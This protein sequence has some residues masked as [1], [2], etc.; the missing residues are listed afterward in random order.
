MTNY[1]P[2]PAFTQNPSFTGFPWNFNLS[3]GSQMTWPAGSALSPD[4]RFLYVACNSDNSVAVIDTTQKKL[5]QQVAVGYF[6]YGVS[7]SNDGQTVTVSNW[8]IT[9]YKFTNPTY[10]SGILT[11]LAPTAGNQPDGFYVPVTST[12]GAFPQTS[13]ISILTAP[14]GDG[15]QL[16]PVSSV[17]QGHTLD[18]LNTIGDTHPS[19]T[20]I[21]DN[22]SVQVLYVTKS[23][24]DR[25]GVIT[26]AN[27]ESIADIDLSPLK[28]GGV[29]GN[30]LV[31]AYPNAIVISPDKTR[32]YVAEAGINSVAVL[33]TTNPLQPALLGRIPTGW[34][35][36]ALAI[37]GDGRYLYVANAKGVGEDINPKINTK[38]RSSAPPSGLASDP[39]TDSHCIFGTVQKIDLNSTQLR[40]FNVLANNFS[41]RKQADASVVPIGGGP[42]GKIK[43]VFLFSRRI[44]VRY[45]A[46]QR[47]SFR[48]VRQREFQ[49]PGRLGVYKPAVYGCYRESADSGTAPSPPRSTTIPIRKKAMPAIISAHRELRPTIPRRPC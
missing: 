37:S 1:T 8:G 10:D 31:G 32:M 4:G 17:Y 7:L 15:S 40:A 49:Q 45:D 47:Q 9:E 38:H 23:N 3:G 48:S 14:G 41:V 44:D 35:P 2:D 21:L 36:T 30:D 39:D 20:A 43:H 46:G 24:S 5:V 6:P 19:A 28:V 27:N 33:D 22:G 42:S 18:P 16:F 13:S 12:S 29:S 25:L 26:L 34:Y 11:A